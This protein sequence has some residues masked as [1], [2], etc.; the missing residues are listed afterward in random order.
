MEVIVVLPP[1]PVNE[2][3]HNGPFA[4]VGRLDSGNGWNLKIVE[5][6]DMAVRNAVGIQSRIRVLY[7][8]FGLSQASSTAVD[9]LILLFAAKVLLAPERHIALLD[10]VGYFANTIAAIAFSLLWHHSPGKRI[11][12]VFGFLGMGIPI[13]LFSSIGTMWMA[14][15]LTT[16]FEA[17]MIL[18][19]AIT[20]SYLLETHSRAELPSAYG[21]LHASGFLGSALGL[22]LSMG[23]LAVASHFV[24]GG[25]GERT[26]F[27]VLG[28]LAVLAAAGAWHATVGMDA[29]QD[30]VGLFQ[31]LSHA[32]STL[33]TWFRWRHHHTP[34]LGAKPLSEPVLNDSM[35]IFLLLTTLLYA[36]MGMS[37]TGTLLYMISELEVLPSLT[38]LAILIFRLAAS[39]VSNP[40]GNHLNQLMPLRM[41]QMAGSWRF[42][43]VMVLGLV[44]LLPVGRW[45]IMAVLPLVAACGISWGIMGVTGPVSASA[46]VATKRQPAAYLMFVAASSGATGAGAWLAS[47]TAPT[48]GFPALF[49]ISGLIFGSALLLWHK[50]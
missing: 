21:Q 34:R 16:L 20:T 13:F 40:A 29:A 26:L 31:R 48:L 42:L 45:G 24:G 43:A 18:P 27:A 2:P 25:I 10:A 39:L 19:G 6:I 8:S 28:V 4:P 1:N 7:A 15:T 41:Q 35:K 11:F 3:W 23:W 36:G 22:L 37:F 14:Y 17:L 47:L 12:A 44:T 50:L 46:M 33:R 32:V 49:G 9:A 38:L 5:V 30:K